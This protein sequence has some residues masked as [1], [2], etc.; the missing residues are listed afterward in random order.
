MA[1]PV[2]FLRW[3][4]GPLLPERRSK[5]PVLVD[6]HQFEAEG[7]IPELQAVPLSTDVFDLSGWFT[8]ISSFLAEVVSFLILL[9]ICSSVVVPAFNQRSASSEFKYWTRR[10]A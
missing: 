9:H 10:R 2:C 3:L 6:W 5:L 1:G 7:S 4:G 8:F